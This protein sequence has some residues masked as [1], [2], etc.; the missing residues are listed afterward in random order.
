VTARIEKARKPK[1]KDAPG[2]YHPHCPVHGVRWPLVGCRECT[3]DAAKST[4]HVLDADGHRLVESDLPFWTHGTR[5][6][7]RHI[8]GV[9]GTSLCLRGGPEEIEGAVR[10]EANQGT[11]QD[12]LLPWEVG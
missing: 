11:P 6:P 3:K 10:D 12:H 8:R 1:L 9:D 7:C 2:A 5:Y 4:L